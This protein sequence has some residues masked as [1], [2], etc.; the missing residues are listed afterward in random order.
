MDALVVGVVCGWGTVVVSL[1]FGILFEL[2]A[3][4][5]ELIRR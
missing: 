2:Q 3:I 1:L 4:K 5:S